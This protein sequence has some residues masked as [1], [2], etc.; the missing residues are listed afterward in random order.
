MSASYSEL[1]HDSLLGI[2]ERLMIVP[3]AHHVRILCLSVL[4]CSSA[5]GADPAREYD[6]VVYGGV[7]CG[8]AAAIASQREGTKTLLIEPTRHVGGLNTSGVNTA[9]ADHMLKWTFGGIAMEFYQKLGKHY[10]KDEPAFLFE[11]G[12]AEKTFISMLD[13]AGVTVRYGS[14]V[15]TSEK[16]GATICS[17]TLEDGSKIHAKVFIDAS[18]EGD[19]MARAGV[20]YTW[21]RESRDQYGEDAAGVRLD[22]TIR[23]AATV[24]ENGKLLPGI[25]GWA[26]DFKEGAADPSVMNFNWRLC[27]TSDPAF[28][29]PLPDPHNYDRNRY[30]LLENWLREKQ[31]AGQTVVLG[32]LVSLLGRRPDPSK[33]EV[34]NKQAAIISTG[35]FGGQKDYPDADY[36]TRD[37]IV[38]D[39]TDYTTGFFRF[40]ASDPVVPD[41]LR[42]ETS[43]WGLDAG[44]FTDNGNWP[45]QLYVREAR[46]MTG[47][48]VM[49]Q[50]DIQQDRRKDDAIAVGSHFIDSHHVRRLAVSPTE[51]I[52]EGRIWRRGQAYQIP[53]RAI[54]P[55]KEQ[56]ANLLVPGAASFSHVAYCAYRVESTWMMAGH[57]AGTAA[58]LAVTSGTPVQAVDVGS[59]QRKLRE[60]RQIIDFIPGAPESYPGT[61]DNEF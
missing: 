50:K 32:D 61:I 6:V 24:D 28:R 39:H 27:F 29:R 4:L 56:C 19:L 57:A 60:A 44:E 47:A 34:N 48:W 53:Y 5:S 42:R 11:S 37:R 49:T 23:K 16:D 52:N 43:Q 51:F 46:R 40:L 45:Y 13:E 33:R 38:A 1:F 12:A 3:S 30:R 54:T 8:I 58:S 14:R 59:L 36:A 7:P 25:D 22:K 21:G 15:T 10:G 2:F 18:Y 20:T 17:L 41:S 9:E 31:A 26:R 35:Y 55:K